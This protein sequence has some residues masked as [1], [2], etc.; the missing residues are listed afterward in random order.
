MAIDSIYIVALLL[1]PVFLE[2]AKIRIRIE[3]QMN[4]IIIAALL[5]FVS[6]AF[7]TSFWNTTV[8]IGGIP[9]FASIA[10]ELAGLVLLLVGAIWAV[11]ELIKQ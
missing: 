2:Y 8:F 11:L 5:L 7:N 3:R 1:A 6:V 4:F 10:F 9:N